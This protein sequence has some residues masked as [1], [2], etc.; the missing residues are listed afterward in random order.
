MQYEGRARRNGRYELGG[1][2]SERGGSGGGG[3]SGGRLA[4]APQQL[5]HGTPVKSLSELIARLSAA[6]QLEESSSPV[7]AEKL[8]QANVLLDQG[9]SNAQ[10]ET[11]YDVPNAAK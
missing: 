5:F 8:A 4:G 6:A 9:R 10:V 3:T 2:G 7:S 11:E 1:R